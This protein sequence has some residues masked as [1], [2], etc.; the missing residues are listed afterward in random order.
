MRPARSDD[1]AVGG[2]RFHPAPA[3]LRVR[4]GGRGYH[5]LAG[6]VL[7]N[8]WAAAVEEE[9]R[10]LYLLGTRPRSGAVARGRIGAPGVDAVA[11]RHVP[12]LGPLVGGGARLVHVFRLDR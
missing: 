11:L 8:A 9:G 12:E 10:R 7:K 1:G 2:L 5:V 4:M 6:A 3:V